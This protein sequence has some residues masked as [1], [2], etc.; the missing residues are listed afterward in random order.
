VRAAHAINAGRMPEVP[1]RRWDANAFALVDDDETLDGETLARETSARDAES[2]SLE[3]KTGGQTWSGADCVWITLADDSPAGYEGAL[4]SLFDGSLPK[5]AGLDPA[6]DV[7]VLTPFRR[8]PA[9]TSQLNAFLQA[10]LNPPARGRLETRVGDVTLREG[11]RVLQ[12]RNDYT[13]E[14]FNGDLGTVV[15]VDGDGSVRVV[16]GA[17]ATGA[18]DDDE[19]ENDAAEVSSTTSEKKPLL[20]SGKSGETAE[21]GPTRSSLDPIARALKSLDGGGGREVSYSR[22]EC[23]D[24]LPAWALTVHKA[25]GSEYRAVVL[26][27]ANAHRPLLRRELVYTAASRAKEALIVISPP[28]AMRVAVETVGNDRRCTTLARRLAPLAPEAPSCPATAAVAA[29]ADAAA[30]KKETEEA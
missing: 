10:R 17:A 7:Q 14:V 28:S 29:A 2:K 15:A 24:L 27:L 1:V 11:D 30:R 25:Q 26:C 13:K 8:G 12:Q 4:E 16:F 9:S 20:A 5:L 3:K 19:T 18:A 21:F 23:R 6:R 22:A